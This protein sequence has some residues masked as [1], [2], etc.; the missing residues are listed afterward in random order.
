MKD[1][2]RTILVLSKSINVHLMYSNGKNDSHVCHS[3]NTENALK[4]LA[5]GNHYLLV[6]D[7]TISSDDI[8]LIIART[9]EHKNRCEIIQR[10]LYAQT[11]AIEKLINLHSME[12][13]TNLDHRGDSDESPL[14]YDKKSLL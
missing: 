10:A 13:T 8:D 5:E 9:Q 11:C 4:S 14:Q 6:C 2:N 12:L 7:E 3:F 1:S